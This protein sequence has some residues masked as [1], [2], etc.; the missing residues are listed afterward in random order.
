MKNKLIRDSIHGYI[1]IPEIIVNKIIDTPVFQR[2]RQIEQTSMRALYPSAHHDRFVHSLGVYHL[3]KMAYAG[4]INNIKSQ[5][6]YE[7]NKKFWESYGI[8]FELACLLHDCAH[9][10]MS[11]SF[12]YGYIQTSNP[13]DCKEKKD[14]LLS[15]MIHGLDKNEDKNLIEQCNRDVDAYFSNPRKIAPHEM[16][17]AILVSEYFGKEGILSEK[18]VICDILNELLDKEISSKQLYEYIIFIQRAIVGLPYSDIDSDH[19]TLYLENCFKNCLISLLNGNFFDVDKLDYIIRDTIESGANN[20]S[21]DIPRILNALTLVEIHQFEKETDVQ[22]LELNNSVY[23]NGC[24]S[25]V[26]DKSEKSDCECTLNLSGVK[27]EGL[28]TGTIEFKGVNNNL[29]T[30]TS[31]QCSG[32]AR[33]ENPTKI[34]AIVGESCKMTGRFNGH[35]Q[36]MSHTDLGKIDGLINAKI[37]GKIAGEI[38][39]YINTDVSHKLTYRVGYLKTAI[40]VIEDTLIARNRLYLWIYAHHKVTYHDYILRQGILRSYLEEAHA[41]MGEFEK[42]QIANELLAKSMSIDDMFFETNKSPNYLL[43][44]GDLIHK[45]KMSLIKSKENNPFAEQWLSRNH[46]YPVWKSYAEYNNF[47]ANLTSEQRQKMWK[48]LFNNTTMGVSTDELPSEANSSEFDNSILKTF[49]DE[50]QYTWIKPAGFKLK[51]MNVSNI[52]IVLSDNSV[53]RFK[54][55][56]TQAKVTEQYV[57]ESFFYLFTSHKFSPDQKLQLISYLKTEVKKQ[58]N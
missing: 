47:F 21:I 45:M 56:I 52:Y 27:L 38:V 35:I 23:F 51:E 20:I 26:A 18:G 46:M 50:N 5:S 25:T 37:S 10:P 58:D 53:K 22:D 1:E 54:D 15:S 8:C 30:P 24:N 16:V 7:E 33:F 39:G 42:N 49:S 48:L 13:E 11:H 41:D 6:F 29:K 36:M 43:N 55:V 40:S 4:L 31:E 57:D 12:E 19:G 2:L 32:F 14:R 34:T 3:G 44:D 17:S 28:F 9:A